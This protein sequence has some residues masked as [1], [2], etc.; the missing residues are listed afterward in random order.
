MYN[1]LNFLASK[2]KVTLNRLT[3]H[4]NQ[5]I[6][7]IDLCKTKHSLVKL[8]FYGDYEEFKRAICLL[9]EQIQLTMIESILNEFT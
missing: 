1:E 8:Y 9:I 2:H 5:S 7:A 3:G 6:T 4:K